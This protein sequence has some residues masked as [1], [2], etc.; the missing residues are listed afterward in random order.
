[1]K[2]TWRRTWPHTPNDGTGTHPDY[3]DRRARV[4][5]E[6]GGTRWWWFVSD[7]RKIGTGIEETKEEAKEAAEEV[8]FGE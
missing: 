4:Y 3:P 7:W 8:F 5:L 6:A 2:L 1:M